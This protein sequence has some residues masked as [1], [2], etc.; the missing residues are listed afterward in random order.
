MNVEQ[1]LLRSRR[2]KIPQNTLILFIF[3]Y[4]RA[5]EEKKKEMQVFD[6]SFSVN[7]TRTLRQVLHMII[8]Y[9]LY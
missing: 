9:I 8:Y 1:Y 3:L 2:K 4:T 5:E 6:S 7:E